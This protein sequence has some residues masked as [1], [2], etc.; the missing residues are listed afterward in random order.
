MKVLTH[1]VVRPIS[2]QEQ[3]YQVT[4]AL[5]QVQSRR[6]RLVIFRESIPINQEAIS[7]WE[8]ANITP[9]AIN[10]SL[11]ERLKEM[12]EKRRSNHVMGI[13]KQLLAE[14][15]QGLPLLIHHFEMLFLPALMI[16]P[17]S[18]L[19]ALSIDRTLVVSWP[20]QLKEDKISYATPDHPEHLEP[21]AIDAIVVR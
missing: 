4:K 2:S 1:K 20:G 14:T 21:T 6:H 11:S 15:D 10:L 7:D 16:N 5:A 13:L 19:E 18:L 3:I 12:P 9:V 8:Q 17:I